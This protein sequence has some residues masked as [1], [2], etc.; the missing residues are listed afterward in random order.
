MTPRAAAI[1]EW[2]KRFRA[3]PKVYLT[4]YKN[5]EYTGQVYESQQ[6]AEQEVAFELKRGNR[7]G[8]V[9]IPVH[10]LELAQERWADGQVSP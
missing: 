7:V 6:A 2:Q 4:V 10:S 8:L 1:L 9:A 5:G 3:Q